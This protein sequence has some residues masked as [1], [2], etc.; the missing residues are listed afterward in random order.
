MG[1]G[2]GGKKH[3]R[4]TVIDLNERECIYKSMLLSI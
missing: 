2:M 3:G 4:R 1:E